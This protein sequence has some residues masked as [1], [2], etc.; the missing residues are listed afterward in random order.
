MASG[1][2]NTG[3][4]GQNQWGDNANQRYVT[5]LLLLE[6]GQKLQKLMQVGETEW[7]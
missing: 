6:L 7:G 3:S 4:W 2:W 1:T 5:G